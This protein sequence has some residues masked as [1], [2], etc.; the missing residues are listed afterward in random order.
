MARAILATLLSGLVMPGLGQLYSRCLKKG[1]LMIAG[2]SVL[3]VSL[4]VAVFMSMRRA[5]LAFG[6]ELPPEAD[7]WSA[8][9]EKAAS[10]DQTFIYII[11]GL[12]A[13]LWLFGVI[14]GFRSGLAYHKSLKLKGS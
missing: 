12:M 7:R 6:D 4:S 13:L 9:A 5:V 3:V 2:M 14:D 1:G 8:L 10:Q 11:V